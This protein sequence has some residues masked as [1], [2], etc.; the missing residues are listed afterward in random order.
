[1]L[2]HS[3]ILSFGGLPL[4]YYGDAIGTLNSLEYL[5]DPTQAA[6][7]RWMN[8]SYFDWK[9]A[10]K[11]HEPGTVE[12]RIF[13]SL[14]KMIALRKETP[15]FADFDNRLLLAVDNSNLLVFSRCDPQQSRSR[16]LVIVNFNVETQA[17]PAEVLRLQG[18]V[19]PEGMKDL[20]TGVRVAVENDALILPALSCQWLID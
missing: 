14:K 8:R 5:A 7:N 18:F 2:L 1:M 6:D 19:Q 12:Q 9:K 20:C 3:V 4:L 10:K 16:V 17:L 11:R 13:S 15:A